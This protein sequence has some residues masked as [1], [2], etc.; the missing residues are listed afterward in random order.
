MRGRFPDGLRVSA[1]EVI[2]K[3][4]M[5][6]ATPTGSSEETAS[7]GDVATGILLRK[8]LMAS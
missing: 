4:S 8:T 3:L 1:N 7:S 5:E 2:D 6:T